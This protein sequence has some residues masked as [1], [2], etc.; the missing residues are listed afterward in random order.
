VWIAA[1]KPDGMHLMKANTVTSFPLGKQELNDEAA[2][3]KALMQATV[4][5]SG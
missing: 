5:G 3:R 1:N 4:A 2:R